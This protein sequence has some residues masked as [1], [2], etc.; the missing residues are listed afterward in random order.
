MRVPEQN[1]PPLET[2]AGQ[3]YFA[4]LRSGDEETT[5]RILNTANSQD[6]NFIYRE[7]LTT[8]N[9]LLRDYLPPRLEIN[10]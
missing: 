7:A 3:K 6:V 2:H 8:E 9:A 4:A 1:V 10:R 5:R